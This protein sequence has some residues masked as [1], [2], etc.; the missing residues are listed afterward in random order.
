M[1]TVMPHSNGIS[2]VDIG[3]K[4]KIDFFPAVMVISALRI[5]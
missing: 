1:V 5:K 2:V 4:E 3:E